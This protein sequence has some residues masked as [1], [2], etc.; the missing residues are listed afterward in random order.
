MDSRINL[1][2]DE[3]RARLDSAGTAC[4]LHMYPGTQHGF[5]NDA[6]AARHDSAAAL[7]WERTLAAFA[8]LRR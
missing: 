2:I 1:G 3:F 6:T 8:L 5:H 7:A 4:R